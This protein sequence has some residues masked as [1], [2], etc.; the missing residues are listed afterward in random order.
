M[1]DGEKDE[2]GPQCH[3]RVEVK[4][5]RSNGWTKARRGAFLAELAQSCN[6][7]RALAMAGMA[8][9]TAYQL[10]RRDPEFAAQWQAALVDPRRARVRQDARGV[11]MGE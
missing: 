1:T 5:V 6:V 4:R 7:G 3:R 9:S 10:R 11:R 8:G 2:I